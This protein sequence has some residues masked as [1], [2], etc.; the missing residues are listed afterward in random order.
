MALEYSLSTSV[1]QMFGCF[2]EPTFFQ[3]TILDLG[4]T[5]QYNTYVVFDYIGAYQVGL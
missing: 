2:L 4:L 3:N 5:E 1:V